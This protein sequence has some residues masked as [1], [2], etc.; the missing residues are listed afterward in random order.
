MRKLWLVLLMAAVAGLYLGLAVPAIH[1]HG[2]DPTKIHSCVNNNSGE[3]KVVSQNATCLN[4]WTPVDWSISGA[5]GPKGDKGDQG[6]QG[7]K[8]DQ[9]LQGDKGDQGLAGLQGLKGDQGN[10]GA[11]GSQGLKGDRGDK[12]DQGLVGLQGAKGDQGLQG[13]PGAKGDKGDK[14]DKGETVVA[15]CSQDSVLSG[16]TCIDTYEASVWKTTDASVIEKIRFGTVT[17]ADLTAASAV[18]LGLSPGDYGAGCPDTGNGCVN[19]YAVSIP[20]VTPSSYINWFQAAAVARNSGKRLP[21]NAEWQAAALG[22]PDGAPCFVSE[23]AVAPVPTGTPGCVSNVGVFD[24]VGNLWEWVADWVPLSAGLSPIC[25]PGLFGTGDDNCLRAPVTTVGGPGALIR[26]GAYG[27]GTRA[28]VFAVFGGL[29]PV[30][31]N[32]STIGFRAAR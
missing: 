30:Y 22:T 11:A 9:G 23:S 31:G 18:Q 26:G 16:I 7:A 28:G 21:T 8:G 17:L 32:D 2:G 27:I 25:D 3:V 1:A 15:T 10:P 4:N 12:G 24:M 14:G 29:T 5:Q 19:L 20:G 13:S 6:L